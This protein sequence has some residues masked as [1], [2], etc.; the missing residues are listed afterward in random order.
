MRGILL[1]RRFLATH[2]QDPLAP[3]AALNLVT[4]YLSLEDYERASALAGEMSALYT[5]P[6]YADSFGY[7]RAVSEWYLGNDSAAMELL[8][9]IAT[10][11]YT[12]ADGSTHASQNRDL[13]LYILAQIHHARQAVE[14]AVAY[15]GRV[16]EVFSDAKQALLGLRHQS[17][18]MEEVTHVA[19]G[20]QAELVLEHRNIER[21]ELLV[22]EVDLMTL[23][24]R[25]RSLA[26]IRGVKLAGIAP[27][28]RKTVSLEVA[29]LRPGSATIELDLDGA[30]AYLVMCRGAEQFISGLVLVSDLDLDV[31]EDPLGGVVRVEAVSRSGGEY[32]RDVDVRV[33]GRGSEEFFAGET[34]LRGLYVA[35]GVVGV[36]TVIA[37]LD[38]GHY[39]FHRGDAAT[40]GIPVIR[41][42]ERPDEG[43]MQQYKAGRSIDY[44]Q[45]ISASNRLKQ[46]DRGGQWRRESKKEQGGLQIQQV[47]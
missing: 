44:F 7:S 39:A 5:D 32:L 46:S 40:W 23:Y 38:G 14:D 16:E 18:S 29:R 6:E 12:E 31:R 35:E 47:Q 9:T 4:A 20:E 42:H 17:I 1:L 15:Y 43:Q 28:L 45:N 30:G 19:P 21:V 27:V 26:D 34:D 24:L 33:V 25:E 10:A 3:D 36:P 11:E 13:A 2:S 37:R 8:E 41:D 22:Y